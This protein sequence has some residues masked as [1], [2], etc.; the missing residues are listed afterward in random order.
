MSE[1]SSAYINAYIEQCG[2][3]G[4]QGGPEFRTRIVEMRNGRERR[5]A[6]W[7]RARHSYTVPYMNIQPDGYAAVK[8]MHYV[9]MGQLRAF[10]FKDE[11]DYQLD[12]EVFG[13]GNGVTTVFQL[14]KQSTLDGVTY[15]R[16]IYVI[17]PGM[18]ITVNGTPVSPVID[19]DRGTITISP[20]PSN[21]AV[22]RATGEFGVWVRFNQDNLPFSI[23]D[24]RAINGSISV[25]E[26]PPPP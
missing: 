5:N 21:G 26:V 11:L 16:E 19:P 3:Y 13:T 25:I 10:K 7:A 18:V 17:E 6:E 4:W 8:Q 15:Q 22:L 20:A 1:S 14:L 12:N 9:C 24:L 2:A 23:D